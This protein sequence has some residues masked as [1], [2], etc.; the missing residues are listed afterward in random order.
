MYKIWRDNSKFAF[1]EVLYFEDRLSGVWKL[2]KLSTFTYKVDTLFEII[3]ESCLK[4]TPNVL[5]V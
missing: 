2:Y 5:C 4:F 3:Y 1:N